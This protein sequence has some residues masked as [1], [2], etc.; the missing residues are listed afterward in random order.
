MKIRG[1]FS[2]CHLKK[3]CLFSRDYVDV[4]TAG[5]SSEAERSVIELRVASH[6]QKIRKSQWCNVC[7]LCLWKYKLICSRRLH[8]QPKVTF[9]CICPQCVF[10]LPFHLSQTALFSQPCTKPKS[11]MSIVS[12]HF[13]FLVLL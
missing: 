11:G 6:K 3:Y 4:V 9:F 13:I 12:K 8:F 10:H 1:P 2:T 7:K 5:W